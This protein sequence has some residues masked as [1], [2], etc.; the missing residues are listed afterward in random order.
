M[1][2]GRV[3]E[4]RGEDGPCRFDPVYHL[5]EQPLVVVIEEGDGCSSV[6]QPTC[7]ANLDEKLRE[8]C[9]Q[10]LYLKLLFSRQYIYLGLIDLV[11]ISVKVEM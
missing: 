11:F 3:E 2:V 10:L 5:Q 1:E 6:S 9:G 4:L 7:P 8:R